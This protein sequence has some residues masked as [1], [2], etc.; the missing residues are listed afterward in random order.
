MRGSDS[1]GE[2]HV[3]LLKLFHCQNVSPA[4]QT[5]TMLS[6]VACCQS[7][8]IQ[9]CAVVSFL[10]CLI[11]YYLPCLTRSHSFCVVRRTEEEGGRREIN[12]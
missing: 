8:A 3:R 1:D 9:P 4:E 6:H 2:F 11:G 5:K 12:F 10:S 7:G